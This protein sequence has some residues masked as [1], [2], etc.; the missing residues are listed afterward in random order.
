MHL[1]ENILQTSSINQITVDFKLKMFFKIKS[2]QQYYFIKS[3]NK[4][5]Q[6]LITK[7]SNKIVSAYLQETYLQL[8]RQY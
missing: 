1:I 2:V 6:E 4:T 5:I 3:Y 8:E 7:I